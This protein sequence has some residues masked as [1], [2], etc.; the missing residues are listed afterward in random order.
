ME[1]IEKKVEEKECPL[2]ILRRGEG[3]RFR[4]GR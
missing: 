2:Y 1:D 4:I 3:M